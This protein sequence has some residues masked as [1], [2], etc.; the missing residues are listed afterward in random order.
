MGASKDRPIPG[1][2]LSTTQASA[3][4]RIGRRIRPKK[5]EQPQCSAL[6]RDGSFSAR[7]QRTVAN[8]HHLRVR[9]DPGLVAEWQGHVLDQRL[10]VLALDPGLEVREPVG[11]R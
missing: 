3:E 4:G 8:H 2:R 7:R 10:E 5:I 9:I 11:R 1:E 6:V